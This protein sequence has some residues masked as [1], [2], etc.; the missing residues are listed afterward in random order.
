MDLIKEG[1]KVT[2]LKDIKMT[3]GIVGK[4]YIYEKI[5]LNLS[6][7][8]GHFD[9][10]LEICYSTLDF[11]CHAFDSE[12]RLPNTVAEIYTRGYF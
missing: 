9:N 2:G 3:K 1:K 6:A 5:D 8:M 4:K 11:D 10:A 12:G 7:K